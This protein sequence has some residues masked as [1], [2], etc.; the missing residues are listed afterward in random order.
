MAA[1]LLQT[2]IFKQ[3][4][5]VIALFVVALFNQLL[6]AGHFPAGFKETFLTPN[7]KKPGLNITGVC[8]YRPISNLSVLSQL[9]ERLVARQLRDY[10]TSADLLP[11]LHS[12]FQAGHS[13]KTAVLWVLSHLRQ[14]VNLG[15]IS[16]LILLDLA[17]A[18]DTVDHEILLRRLRVTFGIDDTV[19]QWF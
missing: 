4:I 18:F 16:A 19:H 14:A 5:N 7:V 10:L 15:N 9:L 8:L 6:A 1:N 11:Q 2:S 13:T 12:S 17:A 3:I